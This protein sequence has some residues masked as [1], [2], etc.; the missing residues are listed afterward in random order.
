MD[1][2]AKIL[3]LVADGIAAVR[4]VVAVFEAT[5]SAAKAINAEGREITDADLTALRDTRNAALD[6]LKS[7]VG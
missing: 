4:D 2:A 1:N 7:R 5:V 3:R 6:R